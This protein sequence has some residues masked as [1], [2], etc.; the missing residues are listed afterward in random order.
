VGPLLDIIEVSTLVITLVTLSLL[1]S[2]YYYINFKET[3]MNIGAEVGEM[4]G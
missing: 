4:I 2:I 3:I 1:A